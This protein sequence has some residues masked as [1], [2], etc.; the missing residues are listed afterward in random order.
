M[1][2][3]KREINH[4]LP[5]HYSQNYI[6]QGDDPAHHTPGRQQS[7]GLVE[8]LLAR[9][10]IQ[11]GDRVLEI[12]A[13]RGAITRALL[14]HGCRVTAIELDQGNMTYLKKRFGNDPQCTLLSGDF[15]SLPLPK[16]N[17]KIF[18]NIPFFITADVLRKITRAPNPPADAYLVLQKQ[19]AVRYCGTAETT[20]KSLLLK[21]RFHMEIT[22]RFSREDFSPRPSV[23]IVLFHL[24]KRAAG[25]LTPG[26]Y[27]S[28]R[29]FVCYCFQNHQTYAEKIFTHRQRKE[30][31]KRYGIWDFR[32][33]SLTYGEWLQLFYCFQQYA[34]PCRKSHVEGSYRRYLKQEAGLQKQYRS[35]SSR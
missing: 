3:R 7:T 23:D 21:P 26:E 15:M 12:G 19:A 6:L 20:L 32:V 28:Y 34:D 4:S 29:E 18:S 16:G 13:G 5:I 9:S 31:G 24:R 10:D 30:L 1:K 25:E 2:E 22:H 17:F 8:K 35:F 27:E 11:P 14:R 33:S